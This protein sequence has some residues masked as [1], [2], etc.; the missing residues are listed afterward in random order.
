[1]KSWTAKNDK[2]TKSKWYK[3]GKDCRVES[4][5][6]GGNYN[7]VKNLQHCILQAKKVT[8]KVV[9]RTVNCKGKRW[10]PTFVG[11]TSENVATVS[12]RRAKCIDL[13][14]RPIAKCIWHC[15][16]CSNH[17]IKL[18][19]KVLRSQICRWSLV[20]HYFDELFLRTQ[21][22]DAQIPLANYKTNGMK[23]LAALFPQCAWW[24]HKLLIY[25]SS[26]CCISNCILFCFTITPKPHHSNDI[27]TI[28]FRVWI[29]P[30][31]IHT[32]SFNQSHILSLTGILRP[33]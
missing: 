1:M 23:W 17:G 22:T 8:L 28:G 18:G 25:P 2:K 24:V 19:L 27:H 5:L 21:E 13:Q 12:I 15:A 16:C 11:W 26:Q 6:E 30:G 29:S 9:F 7:V 33:L 32:T 10:W 4:V 3:I 31:K 14:P 20:T